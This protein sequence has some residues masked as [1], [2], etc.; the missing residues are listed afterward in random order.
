MSPTNKIILG[1][2]QFGLTYGI[3]N[4]LGRPGFSQIES[5]LDAAYAQGIRILDTAEAYGESHDVIGAYHKNSINKFQVITKYSREKE[6]LHSDISKRVKS[7]LRQL[8][9]D[10]LYAYMYHSYQDFE[11]L[12]SLQKRQIQDLKE[13]GQISKLGVSV[14]TNLEIQKLLEYDGIDLIQLPFNLLDGNS[15]RGDVIRQA[16]NKGIEIH[17]RSTFLQGLFFKN[18]NELPVGLRPLKEALLEI[19]KIAE[20]NSVLI[21]DLALAYVSSQNNLDKILIGVDS[22]EQLLSNVKGTELKLSS[23]ILE[24]I[25][26]ITVPRL[27]LLNPS[28]WKL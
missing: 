2:V 7:H 15:Q 22:C 23:D 20:I 26:K 5:I 1:T 12:Y 11:S 14:Y 24:K 17:S 25:E 4:T 10:N 6:D 16:K 18:V 27:E 3:N 21:Q 19:N 28:N 13:T 8:C 9:V